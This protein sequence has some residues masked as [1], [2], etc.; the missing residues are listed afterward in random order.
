M[1]KKIILALLIALL[2]C[3]GLYFFFDKPAHTV[4]DNFAMDT[5]VRIEAFGKNSS[6]E[7]VDEAW[8]EFNNVAKVCNRF[9]DGGD[10]SVFRYNNSKDSTTFKF[11]SYIEELQTFYSKQPKNHLDLQLAAVSD[12][13]NKHK[14]D[15]TVPTQAE[16]DLALKEYKYDFGAIA[17]GFAI[18]KAMAVLEKN[19]VQ[20]AL[21]NAGGNI[22]CFRTKLD[23]TPWKIAIQKPTDE[24]TFL[25]TVTLH[26]G[27]AIATSGN[28]QRFYVANDGKSYH[29]ILDPLTGYPVNYY[30]SV[31]VIAT[32]AVEADFY[33]TDLFLTEPS[34]LAARI[35]SSP[36]IAVIVLDM[37]NNLTVY[38]EKER[39]S[40]T[41]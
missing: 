37:G 3:T 39:F 14:E 4:T 35:S 9:Q 38:G 17:K 20:A 28:Y 23:G 41:K 8:A 11:N 21:I 13:W 26:S 40:E 6:P 27:E 18:D 24:N 25:G 34:L 32:S 12:L 33:S 30:Q 16:I 19:K 5:F 15:K 2:G 22:K 29:H 36:V 31:T 7:I 1:N 10:G